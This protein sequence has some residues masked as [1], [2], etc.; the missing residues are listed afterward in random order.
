MITPQITLRQLQYFLALAETEQI[1]KAALRC[2]VSQS[3]VTIALKNLESSLNATLYTRHSKGVHLTESGERLVQH[4]R[5][6]LNGVQRAVDEIQA[7]PSTMEQQLTIGVTETISVYVAPTVLSAIQERYPGLQIQLV[8]H[9]RPI[10]EEKLLQ[11]ELDLAIMLVSNLTA[12]S[13]LKYHTM[14]KSPRR[15]WTH[16]DHELQQYSQVNLEDI[17]R[18]DYILLDMDEHTDTMARIWQNHHVQPHVVFQS[19]SPEAIRSMVAFQRGITILSDLVYRP[20]SLEG[21]RVL[22]QNI[23]Q[24]IPT[25]DIGCVW[26]TDRPLSPAIKSFIQ[27]LE[28]SIKMIGHS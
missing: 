22:R 15:L 7:T 5:H 26:A 2:N 10:I 16:P 25:M 23:A 1:S 20:W 9:P 13:R 28:N 21:R 6:I 14:L 24:T 11:G 19:Q 4:A 27:F 8:E 18:Y 3:S 12:D 17:A